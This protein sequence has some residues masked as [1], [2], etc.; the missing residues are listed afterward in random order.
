MF[1]LILESE[2]WSGAA[3]SRNFRDDWSLGRNEVSAPAS[4]YR[5]D[6]DIS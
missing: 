4:G 2:L 3:R 6:T 5:L 1:F